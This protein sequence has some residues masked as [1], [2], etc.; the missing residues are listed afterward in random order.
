MNFIARSHEYFGAEYYPRGDN[1]SISYTIPNASITVDFLVK[2]W[3][4]GGRNDTTLEYCPI[5][6]EVKNVDHV[7]ISNGDDFL[8]NCADNNL[9]YKRD[10]SLSFNKPIN[11]RN[12]TLNFLTIPKKGHSGWLINVTGKVL[13]RISYLRVHTCAFFIKSLKAPSTC[14]LNNE[15]MV[16]NHESTKN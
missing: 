5:E 9:V 10:N 11:S 13:D 16:L 3:N 14:R 1:M 12:N 15:F 2:Y 4:I 8:I 7:I 6:R